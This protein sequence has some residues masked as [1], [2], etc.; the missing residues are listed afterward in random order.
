MF[1]ND[2]PGD[3]MREMAVKVA[4]VLLCSVAHR[5]M[6]TI[7]FGRTEFSRCGLPVLTGQLQGRDTQSPAKDCIEAVKKVTNVATIQQW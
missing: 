5:S 2:C 4:D 1:Y 3:G 6:E 7:I